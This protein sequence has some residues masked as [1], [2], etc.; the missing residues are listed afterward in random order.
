MQRLSAVEAEARA[1]GARIR[2]TD[3]TTLIELGPVSYILVP[4]PGCLSMVVTGQRNWDFAYQGAQE[5]LGSEF[6]ISRDPKMQR[7]ID[8]SPL[9]F[10]L[11]SLV[12][13]ASIMTLI[14]K[15]WSD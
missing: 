12:L 11:I 9:A 14:Y 6:V 4:T 5:L 15:M 1:M 10:S 3:Q 2:K 13:I 7:L 8:Y